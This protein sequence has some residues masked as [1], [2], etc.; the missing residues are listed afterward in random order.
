MFA[1]CCSNLISYNITGQ[2]P[3]WW[4]KLMSHLLRVLSY[5]HAQREAQLYLCTLLPFAMPRVTWFFYRSITS[6]VEIF[7]SSWS[8]SFCRLHAHVWVF[9]PRRPLQLLSI[10]NFNTVKM[11][12]PRAGLLDL[13]SPWPSCSVGQLSRLVAQWYW[14]LVLTKLLGWILL[15]ECLFLL[16]WMKVYK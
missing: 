15:M 11:P 2:G 14:L 4:C 1:L 10:Y 9:L 7:W 8:W 6:I 3:F 13:A 12:T 16:A 5:G